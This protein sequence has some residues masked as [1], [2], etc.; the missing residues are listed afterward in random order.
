MKNTQATIRDLAIRLDISISTVSRAL[1]N[2]P[3]VNPATKKAVLELA[4]KLN[5]EPNR[6]AQ[7]LRSKKTNTLGVVVP[8][9]NLHFFSSAISGIQEYAALHNYSVIICQSLESFK[10]EE[11]TIH[12]LVANRVDGLLIS[13]SSQTNHIKHLEPLV[14]KKI[15]IVL[16]DRVIDGLNATRVVVD[17]R[18][19]SFKAV[20]Y[21]IR[22]GCKRIA[23]LGGPSHLYISEQRKEGYLDALKKHNLKIDTN[24]I[25][26]CHD[27]INEPTE[28]CAELL[29]SKE[30][31]DAFFACMIPSPF[32]LSR[33]LKQ[34][35]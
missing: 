19:G 10:T 8:Q 22:T 11:A 26:H 29:N 20:D 15:P 17:D 21:L 32:K 30:R 9:I 18:D 28:A 7:S 16:F 34:R 27:L 24:L 14:R 35:D 25:V 1:R 2:A 3:D 12:M 13:L 4:E 33:S 6:V 23:Y 5:Y 31:P